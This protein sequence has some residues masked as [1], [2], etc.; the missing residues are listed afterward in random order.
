MPSTEGI[1]A[2]NEAKMTHKVSPG[3]QDT[4]HQRPRL[5]EEVVS[6]TSGNRAHHYPAAPKIYPDASSTA[7][8]IAK[9]EVAAEGQ[10]TEFCK[11]Q[12]LDIGTFKL[13][14]S[15]PP[16]NEVPFY[17]EFTIEKNPCGDASLDRESLS[18]AD[19][20]EL[21]LTI[22]RAGSESLGDVI[23]SCG[24]YQV[25]TGSWIGRFV[26]LLTRTLTAMEQQRLSTACKSAGDIRVGGS[27][28]RSRW[29]HGLPFG[30]PV[31]VP[32]APTAPA[33]V[34]PAT[35]STAPPTATPAVPTVAPTT[36]HTV[37]PT[38]ASTSTP[39]DLPTTLGP[40]DTAP[41]T[42]DASTA[43]TKT[44]T[45]ALTTS[46]EA[47]TASTEAMTTSTEPLTASTEALTTSTGPLTTATGPPT[48]TTPPLATETS[49]TAP[50]STPAVTT[51]AAETSS[52]APTSTPALTA[53]AAET[54]STAPT[55]TA[56]LT[57]TASETSST[58]PT[59]TPSLTTTAAETTAS[60]TC[61]NLEFTLTWTTAED[62]DL[63]VQTPSGVSIF[64]P[65][66]PTSVGSKNQDDGVEGKVFQLGTATETVTITCPFESGEYKVIVADNGRF[67][68]GDGICY[69]TNSY[70]LL[71]SSG[72][73][74]YEGPTTR[75]TTGSSGTDTTFWVTV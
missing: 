68:N 71:A 11:P 17:F 39:T 58:A 24:I 2:A 15:T 43:P 6:Y 35:I 3:Y 69:G 52:I 38:F 67:F 5:A 57:T 54:S 48:S 27:I 25:A 75:T 51:T 65:T 32:I 41:Q 14:D 36:S 44:S 61:T 18:Q 64:D 63:F 37:A 28:T 20:M 22:C 47:M 10:R 1:P 56:A 45:E 55:S 59:S 49:S 40:E 46:T 23:I 31:P 26:F 53:T 33:T 70:T 74:I 42:T 19:M 72:A 34:A 62:L 16:S 21:E 66:L 29:R 60:T 4:P 13:S 7:Y 8:K 9:G 30:L 50:I 12:S 73:V